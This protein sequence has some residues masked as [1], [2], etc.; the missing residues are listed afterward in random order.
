MLSPEE[1]WSLVSCPLETTWVEIHT[2]HLGHSLKIIRFGQ[3][4]TSIN[5]GLWCLIVRKN[6]FTHACY[7]KFLCLVLK[8]PFLNYD[9]LLISGHHSQ[10]RTNVIFI[11]SKIFFLMR[12]YYRSKLLSLQITVTSFFCI[13]LFHEICPLCCWLITGFVSIPAIRFFWDNKIYKYTPPM[14]FLYSC[15][16]VCF[17]YTEFLCDGL[18]STFMVLF[19]LLLQEK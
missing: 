10:L 2:F 7:D 5:I 9:T 8:Y 14:T 19:N 6:S 1:C 12:F 18:Y 13:L 11:E 3:V 16:T 17:P 4:V 15:S